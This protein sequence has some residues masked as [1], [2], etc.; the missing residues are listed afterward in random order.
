MRNYSLLFILVLISF[1]AFSQNQFDNKKDT[2]QYPYW[3]DMMKNDSVNFFQTQRAFQLY[4][5][6]RPICKGCGYNVFKRWEYMRKK[7]IDS[8]GFL[9]RYPKSSISNNKKNELKTFGVNS[10]TTV[11]PCAVDTFWTEIGPYNLSNAGRIN[12]LAFHPTDTNIILAGSPSGGLWKTTDRGITWKQLAANTDLISISSIAI[13]EQNPAIIYCGTGDANG[14]DGIGRGVYK[15]ID[16]GNTWQ[17]INNGMFP[18][19][20]TRIIIDPNNPDI[21]LCSG[22][23]GIFRS[24]DAGNS[25]KACTFSGDKY[26]KD[27]LFQPGQS[28][29]V[30]ACSGGNF[31]KSIDSGKSYT[32]ITKGLPNYAYRSAIAVS[33]SD[34]TYVYFLMCE[35]NAFIG[36]YRS[37]NSG[38]SF[39][40]M[41]T[42]PN[43]M[44]Y[45]S[46]GSGAGGQAFY[47]MDIAVHP[48]NKNEIYVGGINIF[49]STDG[50]KNWTINAH[51]TAQNAPYVHADIHT[52]SYQKL[53][54]F[55][56]T[57]CDGGV[58]TN[59]GAWHSLSIGL[60]VH[61]TYKISTGNTGLINAGFQDNGS[62]ITSTIDSKLFN[63]TTGGDG[64]DN[65]INFYNDKLY[66]TSSQNGVIYRKGAT[67]AK[68]GLNGINENG[69]WVTPFVL[70]EGNPAQMFA[71]YI[72]IWR[73][74][75]VESGTISFD[76]IC[77]QNANSSSLFI[78]HIE[79]SPVKN[80]VLYFTRENGT[81]FKTS[82]ANNNNPTW[83]NLSSKKPKSGFIND[84]ECSYNDSNTLFIA[85][86]N[87]I[88]RSSD[89][90]N[91]WSNFSY[92]LP[93]ATI[94]AISLDSS[95]LHQAMYCATSNGVYYYDTLIKSWQ[96]FNSGFPEN[97]KITDIEISYNKI[98]SSYNR[99]YASTYGR[100]IWS[101]KLKNFKDLKPSASFINIGNKMFCIESKRTLSDSSIGTN[102]MHRWS[103]TPS[104]ALYDNN[105]SL[106]VN[107]SI[108][109]KK[110]GR[111]TIKKTVSNCLGS[112][113]FEIS[114]F[115]ILDSLK[116][117][118]C[119]GTTTNKSNPGDFGI[120]N[121]VIGPYSR[122]SS[123]TKSSGEYQD[124]SCGTIFLL[125]SDTTYS[126]QIRVNS[127][128]NEYVKIYIDLNDDGTFKETEVVKTLYGKGNIVDNI[129]IPKNIVKNKGI[130]MRCISDYN[131]IDT[132]QCPTL[133]FGQTEDHLVYIEEEVADFRT[134]KSSACIGETI[135]VSDTSR[136][137]YINYHWEFGADCQPKSADGPGPF[138][139]K[140]ST[141]GSKTIRLEI[142]GNGTRIKTMQIEIKDKPD[143][144][145]KAISDDST[146]CIGS[147]IT[148]FD[149]I[150]SNVGLQYKWIK[151]G[152]L[153]SQN[154]SLIYNSL[155]LSDSGLYTLVADNG[156]QQDTSDVFQLEVFKQ[157]ELN[158][159]VNDS[160]QCF[161]QNQFTL[162]NKKP[163]PST[164]YYWEDELNNQYTDTILNIQFTS[165][166]QHTVHLN[167]K[168]DKNC[169]NHISQRLQLNALPDT[170]FTVLKIAN[171][172][173]KFVPKDSMLSAYLWQFGDGNSSTNKSPSYTYTQSGTYV[174]KLRVET[175]DACLDSNTTTLN[176]ENSHINDLNG[177]TN[178]SIYPNPS[179]GT[180]RIHA[181]H[182][183]NESCQWMLYNS[184]G[185]LIQ[186]NYIESDQFCIDH[187]IDLSDF[188]LSNGIYFLKLVSGQ[189]NLT[190]QFIYMGN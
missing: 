176:A 153:I 179:F 170:G 45:S 112:D 102:L 5:H 53:T 59:Q 149:D 32:R 172:L 95:D 169:Q 122:F 12:A 77:D 91:T 116:P 6:N 81:L 13:N 128:V 83:V 142:N 39:S 143:I 16:S 132:V 35:F 145:I 8:A 66:Y 58:Y 185:V 33:E 24:L 82:N 7:E 50:G 22:D 74:T 162:I 94:Y 103:S 159:W 118:L 78:A 28:D 97:V 101:S 29:I 31:F 164:T 150:N 60:G 115:Y 62:Y 49:R 65:A 154:D 43:I 93:N 36:L 92:N 4:W 148:L 76:N 2:S 188:N 168:S 11:F 79:N 155:L 123:T 84:I 17:A 15:S 64:M 52:L 182:N 108:G 121:V 175:N 131:P 105:D 178:F 55:L 47:C 157:P 184:E 125:K 90:G 89:G 165:I 138:Q 156:C 73:S 106:S 181:E 163:N 140:Y 166:G 38:D 127:L 111:Y 86:A 129:Y 69:D 114:N 107:N 48:T 88:Y 51:Y 21:L 146:F 110:A 19:I 134:D 141:S 147:R 167:A 34:P 161:N 171:L 139:I 20:I 130:R 187:I 151:E 137:A 61:Q 120:S 80:D 96:L 9:L 85:I 75:N 14:S 189:K 186:S 26:I 174:I 1:T 30:F 98:S 126:L 25:W 124:L 71:G 180:I 133:I 37:V 136:G 27:M 100:G 152:Q 70:Q 109:F 173:Y 10:S 18:T 177:F 56:Y 72:N 183:S 113:S 44:D 23:K 99:I 54:K 117:T 42:S 63:S 68:N 119:H 104:Y 144:A 190:T 87:S 40:M 3:I 41:S 160:I 135:S 158:I 57:G 67:I 46:N